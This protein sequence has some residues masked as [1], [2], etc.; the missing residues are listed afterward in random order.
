MQFSNQEKFS[1]WYKKFKWSFLNKLKIYKACSEAKKSK[2]RGRVKGREGGEGAIVIAITDTW[3]TMPCRLFS[4]PYSSYVM[5]SLISSLCFEFFWQFSVSFF[6]SFTLFVSTWSF[7]NTE[8][9]QNFPSFFLREP[10]NIL[11]ILQSFCF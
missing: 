10:G 9:L 2:E 1:F 4:R 7:D 5:F 3:F 8:W 11:T 6:L